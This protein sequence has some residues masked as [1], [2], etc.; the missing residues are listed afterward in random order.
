MNPSKKFEEKEKEIKQ[1]NE[2]IKQL[3]EKRDNLLDKDEQSY[4][5]REILVMFMK[6]YEAH[7]ADFK[8][9]LVKLEADK[10]WFKKLVEEEKRNEIR[11]NTLVA[12]IQGTSLINHF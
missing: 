2:E 5:K 12:P 9:Q 8:L 4:T 10:E 3:K 7:L 1:L 6:E 11:N